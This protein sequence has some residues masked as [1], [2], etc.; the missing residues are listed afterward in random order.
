M[1]TLKITNPGLPVGGYLCTFEGIDET[2]HPDYGEGFRWKFKCLK[3]EHAGR[4][5]SAT[6]KREL[7]LRNKAGRLLAALLGTSPSDGLNDDPDL[8]IGNEYFV[9]VG[10]SQSGDSTRVE[11]FVPAG[12]GEPF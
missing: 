8:Y 3:G 7:T 12:D 2:E 10:A 9:T 6:T 4:E 11:S 5:T 1:S